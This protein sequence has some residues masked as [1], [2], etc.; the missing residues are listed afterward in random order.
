MLACK[1]IWKKYDAMLYIFENSK[2]VFINI[3]EKLKHLIPII[4]N[5]LQMNWS[6]LFIL[7]L[8]LMELK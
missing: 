3:K 7:N 8:V 2:G 6:M 5:I 4:K 1:T